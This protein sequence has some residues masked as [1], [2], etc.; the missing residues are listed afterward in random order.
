MKVWKKILDGRLKQIVNI[1]DNQ[2][3]FSAGKSTTNAIFI[4]QKYTEKKKRLY[5]IFINLDSREG[6]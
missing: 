5:H 6:F 1:S 3:G 2:F 4:Q